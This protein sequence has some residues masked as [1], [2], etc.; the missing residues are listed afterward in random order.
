[1]STP[2]KTH[3]REAAAALGLLGFSL[4][5]AC[6]RAGAQESMLAGLG[7]HKNSAGTQVD[8]NSQ[9]Q[10]LDNRSTGPV[11]STGGKGSALANAG[12]RVDLAGT[13]Q[14]NGVGLAAM[15]VRQSQVQVLGNRVTGFIH[16]LGGAA[17]ANM[18][19]AASA[20]G[21]KQLTASRLL[22]QGNRAAEVAAFGAK[23]EVLLGTGSLQM[24]GRA[25]A[26]SV[27]LDATDVSNSEL[28]VVG[29]DARRVT[30]IGGSA[31]A[32]ALTAAR[33][34]LVDTR[35][36]QTAN[37]AED[38][39]AGG[40]G[41]GV[42]RGT[43]A[44][45]NLTGVAAAN[46]VMLA[47]SQL[48]GAQLVLSRNEA[49]QVIATG[50]SALANSISLTDHQLGGSAGYQA[51]VTGNTA[52]NVQAWGGEG[53]ILGGAL[54]DVRL[55]A[56]AL[57]NTISVTRGELAERPVHQ[58]AANEA[59]D[60]VATGG[61]A[62]GNSL[63]LDNATVR[64]G[65]VLLVGNTADKVRTAG[66]SGS[67]G[68]GA[69]GALERNGRALANTVVADHQSTLERAAITVTGNRGASVT[70]AGGLAAANSVMVTEGRVQNT[71][72]TLAG[73]RADSVQST[74]YAAQAGGGLLFSASQQSAA[75][76]NTL[77]VRGSQLDAATLTVAGNTA[78]R[79]SARGGALQAN[80]IAI[81]N[82][83]GAPSRLSADGALS[84][85]TASDMSTTADSVSGTGGLASR[86]SRARAAANALV[87]HDGAQVDASSPWLV[88][89]NSARGVHAT[90]GTALVNALAAYRSAAVQGTP[91]V[92]AGNTG[93]DIRAAGSGAQ[94]LGVGSKSNGVLAANGLYMDGS[95]ATALAQSSLLVAGNTA[96]Q[97]NADGGRINANAL[98]LNVQGRVQGSSITVAAN[99][100]ADVRSEGREGTV[101]GFAAFGK[102]IGQANANAVQVLGEMRAASLQLI[103]NQAGRVVATEGLAAANSFSQGAGGRVEGVQA[104]VA[105]NTAVS[106]QAEQGSTALANSVQADGTLQGSTVQVMANQ[107]SARAAARDGL[108]NSVRAQSRGRIA[109]SNVT[110]TANQGSG[111][112][113]VA[114]SVDVAGTL[115]G[116]SITILGNQGSARDGG[117]IN[118]VAGSGR[119]TGSQ[120]TV[121]GN[122]GS[123]S[124]GLANSVRADGSITASSITIL[125]NQASAQGSGSKVNS[126]TG[127]GSMKGSQVLIAGN[128]GRASG[129]GLVNGLHNRGSM[130][131]AQVVITGNQGDATGGGTVNSVDN[132][133]Q[134]SGRVIIAGNRG[135]TTLGGT[136]NSLVNRGVVTG[137]VVIAGNQGRA[138]VG[139]VS[140]S[141]INQGLITG[142]VTVVGNNTAAGVGM[143][144]GSVR[145]LGGA[146]TGAV[147]VAGNAAFAANPG[148]TYTLPSMGVVN[149]SVTVLPAFNVLNM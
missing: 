131:G 149:Q 57:A 145:N 135:S 27:L 29:N 47:S 87:L 76:A 19:L 90:G 24:P 83:A 124:G 46:A 31:L 82:G 118:S 69:V 78:S 34:T 93:Q 55:A 17:T 106:T 139:G 86:E 67:I 117:A 1:M 95:G 144:S 123:A 143:T 54:A 91:V 121:I 128:T 28:A 130:S 136:V 94:A 12:M 53:S 16:A 119:I 59:R 26:N 37:R 63:W 2:R 10:V 72:V 115:Q 62:A 96:R 42:G 49:T 127:A 109:G 7:W 33:S 58:L 56:T 116:G 25:S 129:G 92:I 43:I 112:E 64:G 97:L 40:G 74:G 148:Y 66:G 60:V 3:R 142:V 132:R 21:T 138:A 99:T 52:R 81:E 114:N 18:V 14:A 73:N 75:L 100:A 71:A 88:A 32:N 35:I 9:I 122:A 44:Q 84:G 103:A 68:G 141:V 6:G 23:T 137:T 134:L 13:A 102:G 15:D 4:A 104:L 110:V 89:G 36:L 79:L 85:N 48:R 30:S 120:I 22:V 147:G 126:V 146:I 8:A 113:G 140:N 98:S 61:G 133:G 70:G 101:A 5:L 108:A 111:Q 105:A 65:S 38:V 11:V 80:S 51:G 50:G 41:G 39:R 45:V 125:G 77:S 107:G 20:E